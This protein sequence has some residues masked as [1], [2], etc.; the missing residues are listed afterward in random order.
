MPH[1]AIVPA[2]NALL[3]GL[4]SSDA[5]YARLSSVRYFGD[6]LVPPTQALISTAPPQMPKGPRRPRTAS[7]R[8]IMRPLAPSRP[9]YTPWGYCDRLGWS[10]VT[11]GGHPQPSRRPRALK[12]AAAGSAQRRRGGVLRV[13]R[14]T[15]T[16]TRVVG[17]GPGTSARTIRHS[18]IGLLSMTSTKS[19]KIT[20]KLPSYRR[21]NLLK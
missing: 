3:D 7:E 18:Y 16:G 4:P 19:R 2:G 10:V 6:H 15:T 20:K 13:T 12:V 14:V 9:A 11:C 1:G 8:R 5:M 21:V 17:R